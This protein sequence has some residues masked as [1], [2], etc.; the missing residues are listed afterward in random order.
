M[1][2]TSEDNYTKKKFKTQLRAAGEELTQFLMRVLT[3]ETRIK[4]MS[5]LD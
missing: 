4:V 5:Q 1:K 2:Q 3:P